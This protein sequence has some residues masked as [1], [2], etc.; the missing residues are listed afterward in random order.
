MW[1]SVESVASAIPS[2]RV[3]YNNV[4]SEEREERVI[5]IFSGYLAGSAVEMKNGERLFCSQFGLLSTRR[6]RITDSGVFTN[7][8]CTAY[9]SGVGEILI[10]R[11]HFFNNM[12]VPDALKKIASASGREGDGGKEEGS[13]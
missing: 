10:P 3:Y 5:H 1:I 2:M 9:E 13:V 11:G 7:M 6:T 4:D 8:D 12:F